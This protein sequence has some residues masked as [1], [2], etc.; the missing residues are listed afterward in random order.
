MTEQ[1]ELAQKLKGHIDTLDG[2]IRRL[3]ARLKVVETE[4]RDRIQRTISDL[5]SQRGEAESRLD[6]VRR[7]SE[8]AWSELRTG[9]ERAF[10]EIYSGFRRARD[11]NAA[12]ARPAR[13]AGPSEDPA[14]QDRS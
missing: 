14:S 4:A 9:F 11:S 1:S 7:T 2:E 5:W 10:D 6:E 13:P 12:S 8:S 3:D